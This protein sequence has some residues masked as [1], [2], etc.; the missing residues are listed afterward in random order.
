MSAD[1]LI[2]R[3]FKIGTLLWDYFGRERAGGGGGGPFFK[4]PPPV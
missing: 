4:L 2:G 3:G 1:R